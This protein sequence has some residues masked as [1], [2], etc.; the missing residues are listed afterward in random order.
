MRQI[1]A[2][3]QLPSE[4]VH[5]RYHV[6]RDIAYDPMNIFWITE[7]NLTVYP[8]S[9]PLHDIEGSR[10]LLA[11]LKREDHPDMITLYAAA[12]EGQDIAL[13]DDYDPLTDSG[14]PG[15]GLDR[16][17]LIGFI[18]ILLDHGQNLKWSNQPQGKMFTQLSDWQLPEF[19]LISS[20]AP[21]LQDMFYIQNYDPLSPSN[22]QLKTILDFGANIYRPTTSL[23]FG[24]QQFPME[25]LRDKSFKP[26]DHSVRRINLDRNGL[27]ELVSIL[28]EQLQ[29]FST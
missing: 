14:I 26:A 1:T 11:L 23:Y 19:H 15:L 4:T 21:K 3:V 2:W 27:K 24:I 25:A 13:I 17:E 8:L 10:P 20:L 16:Q 18:E 28:Q 12:L 9:K 5:R 29:L 7:R 6:E 22:G